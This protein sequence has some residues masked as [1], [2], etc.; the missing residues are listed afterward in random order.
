MKLAGSYPAEFRS[1]LAFVKVRTGVAYVI[2]DLKLI[3]GKQKESSKGGFEIA[4]IFNP[5][6]AEM[7]PRFPLLVVL[8]HRDLVMCHIFVSCSLSCG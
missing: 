6:S 3:F 4:L 8:S 5:V 2:R 7:E 1:T